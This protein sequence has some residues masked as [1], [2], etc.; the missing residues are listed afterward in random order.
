MAHFLSSLRGR[1][2]LLYVLTLV[3]VAAATA[4]LMLLL[5]NI[6]Q[7]K[8]EAQQHAFR[9]VEVDEDTV[10]PAIWGKNYPLQYDGY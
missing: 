7:R 1:A 2:A 4:G 3:V 8:E 5:G 10:D 6:A 9:V